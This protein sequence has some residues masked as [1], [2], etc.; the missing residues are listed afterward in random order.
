MVKETKEV[1][2]A[3]REK[4]KAAVEVLGFELVGRGICGGRGMWAN[5][6]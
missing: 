5:G 6:A 3:V 4:L 2:P 1:L